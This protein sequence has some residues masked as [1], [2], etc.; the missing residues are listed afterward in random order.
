MLQHLPVKEKIE[1]IEFNRMRK[2]YIVDTLTTVDIQE[3]VK[4]AGKVIQFNEGTIYRESF[5][6]SAFIEV[7]GKLFA[8]RK[9]YNDKHKDLLQWLIEVIIHSVYMEFN[10]SKTSINLVNLKQKLG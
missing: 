8:S 1:N 3:I 7:I 6:K 9:K 10:Y 5:K 4:N 2:G